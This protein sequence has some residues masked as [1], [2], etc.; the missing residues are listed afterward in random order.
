MSSVVITAVS[1]T[2]V[3]FLPVFAMEAAEGKLFKPSAYTKTFALISAV[4]VALFFIP[5]LAH[6]RYKIKIDKRKFSLWSSCILFFGSTITYFVIGNSLI[7]ILTLLSGMSILKVLDDIYLPQMRKSY[8]LLS[9]L[10]YAILIAIFLTRIWM[11]L[12]VTKTL[13][14]NAVFVLG[15]IGVLLI[16][17]WTIIH[18]YQHI[19]TFLLKVKLLFL[20]FVVYIIYAGFQVFTETGQEFMPPLNEG[21]FLLMPS[22]MP[23][24]GVEENTKNLRLLDMTI[25][26]IP[27]VEM[28]VGK[29]GRVGSPLDPAPMLMFENIINYKFEFI[30]NEKG[31]KIRFLYKKGKYVKDEHGQLIPDEKGRYFRQWREKIKSP[32]DIWDEIVAKTKFPGLTSAPKLQPIETRLIMLQTGMRAPMWIKVKGQDLKSIEAVGI[33]LENHLKAVE[34]IKSSSVFAERIVG[35]PYL[36]INLNREKIARYGLKVEDLQ[37]QIQTAIGGVK[38]TTTVEGRERYAIRLR[39]PIDFR[40]DPERIKD[41]Y[42][43]T[44][45][46]G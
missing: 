42:I 32:D 21:S 44:P 13:L 14:T 24:S 45:N 15:T 9:N 35:K 3:S 7:L 37:Y 23:H 27:E 38:V 20:L 8:Q 39:Y 30:T 6:S 36:L 22:S 11:P 33:K 25:I 26:S 43:A 41:I 40:S 34:G 17:F 19:L 5:P 18:Y 46:S 29:A 1:T 12:G 4:I 31:Q 2:I 16:F 10:L 28:V